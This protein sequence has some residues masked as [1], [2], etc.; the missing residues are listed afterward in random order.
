MDRLRRQ[1]V[2][3][4]PLF[5]NQLIPRYCPVAFLWPQKGW[6]IVIETQS[7]LLSFRA[8]FYRYHLP[9]LELTS[10]SRDNGHHARILLMLTPSRKTF[11]SILVPH[12]GGL[13][14]SP[15]RGTSARQRQRASTI[16]P[17]NARE[18]TATRMLDREWGP[19]I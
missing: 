15:V 3:S 12:S 9:F 2:K 19:D 4:K 1:T 5:H 10:S 16:D 8:P 7:S 13:P 18:K 14:F 11:G 17:A 6:S